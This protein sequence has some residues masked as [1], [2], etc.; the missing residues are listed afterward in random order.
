MRRSL[1]FFLCVV[2]LASTGLISRPAGALVGD[3]KEFSLGSPATQPFDLASGP[4]GNFWVVESGTNR[5]ARVTPTGKVTHFAIPAPYHVTESIVRGPDGRMW[6]TESPY[7]VGAISMNGVVKE[8]P[9]AHPPGPGGPGDI[10]VGRYG[11]LW[12]IVSGS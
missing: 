2:V 11:N 7:A 3:V 12:V 1:W 8:Y 10:T 4:D 6:F 9:V 5:L